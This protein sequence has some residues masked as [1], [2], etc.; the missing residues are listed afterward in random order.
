MNKKKENIL[1]PLVGSFAVL[2]HKMN[3]YEHKDDLD[4]KLY[5][6]ERRIKEQFEKRLNEALQKMKEE[7]YLEVSKKIMSEIVNNLE[8]SWINI[9]DDCLKS[10]HF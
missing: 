3:N 2:A 7:I 10:S 8:N 4:I 6:T 9:D 5:E 1:F